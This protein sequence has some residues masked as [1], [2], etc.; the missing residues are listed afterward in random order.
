MNKSKLLSLSAIAL[1]LSSCADGGKSSDS[2]SA[3]N[4]STRVEAEAFESDINIRYVSMDSISKNYV[5]AQNIAAKAQTLVTELQSY[6]VQL[7]NQLQNQA[8]QIQQK[9]QNNGYLSQ[10]SY[11]ADMKELEKK[12]N[13][14]QRQYAQREQ[15]AAVTMDNLQRELRD[16]IMNFINAYNKEKKYDAILYQDAGLFFNPALDITDEIIAGLNNRFTGKAEGNPNATDTNPTLPSQQSNGLGGI[17]LK[18]PA[19]LPTTGNCQ[20]TY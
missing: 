12:N 5:L 10:A 9:A 18:N 3:S 11:E 15:A 20:M 4:D 6:Q 17:G 8:N 2:A 1:I 13:Q 7:Q 16:S 14:F 19:T